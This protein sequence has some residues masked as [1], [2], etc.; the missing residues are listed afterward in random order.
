MNDIYVK[1]RGGRIDDSIS[2]VVLVD[3]DNIGFKCFKPYIANMRKPFVIAVGYRAIQV[4]N[5]MKAYESLFSWF[6]ER[7]IPTS[8]ITTRVARPDLTDYM[9]ILAAMDYLQKNPVMKE[10]RWRILTKDVGLQSAAIPLQ[11]FAR[12][13][14]VTTEEK[15]GVTVTSF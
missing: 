1:L 14:P 2:D 4:Q 13:T 7:D 12:D 8:I 11:Y 6:R 9:L 5:H 3:L 15:C 10:V